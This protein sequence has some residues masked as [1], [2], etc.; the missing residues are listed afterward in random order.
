MRAMGRY[1][2]LLTMIKKALPVAFLLQSQADRMSDQLAGVQWTS[3]WKLA[4]HLLTRLLPLQDSCGNF[5][6]R[7]PA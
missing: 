2:S 5:V 3:L 6:K 1:R 4:G 7:R